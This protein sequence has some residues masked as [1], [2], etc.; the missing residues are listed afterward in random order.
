AARIMFIVVASVM[1]A[2]FLG[3]YAWV[4]GRPTPLAVYGGVPRDMHGSALLAMAG[5]VLDRSFGLLLVAPVFLLAAP[6]IAG[7]VRRGGWP[8]VLLGVAVLAPL[9]GWRMW[10]GGQCPPA[11]F[12]VPL[13]PTLAVALAVRTAA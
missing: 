13:V 8:H 9:A 6:G 7:V 10:W 2:A 3:Y 11:R 5:V 12:L 4:F 1:A